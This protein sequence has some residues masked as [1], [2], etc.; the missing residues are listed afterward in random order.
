MV[1]SKVTIIVIAGNNINREERNRK[2]VKV[3]SE[4]GKKLEAHANDR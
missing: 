2:G 3:M 4:R 1:G